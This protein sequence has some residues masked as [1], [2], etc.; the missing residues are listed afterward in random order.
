[1]IFHSAGTTCLGSSRIG[2]DRVQEPNLKGLQVTSKA[3]VAKAFELIFL[4]PASRA[5]PVFRQFFEGCASRDFS[6]LVPSFGV[7][8]IGTGG[9]SLTLVSFFHL[10]HFNPSNH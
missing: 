3:L 8:E 10:L 7:I 6:L 4:G 2:I 5:A 1:M 9:Y